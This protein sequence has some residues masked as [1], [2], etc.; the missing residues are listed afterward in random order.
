LAD[1]GEHLGEAVIELLA[2]QR[3]I[4]RLEQLP[5]IRDNLHYRYTC[6]RRGRIED[7]PV[8]EKEARLRNGDRMACLAIAETM[9]AAALRNLQQTR[10]RSLLVTEADLRIHRHKGGPPLEICLMVDASGSM[11]GHRIA[12]VKEL[13][14]RLLRQEREPLALFTF[15]EGDIGVKVSATRDTGKMRQ[16]ISGL[17]AGGMTPLGEAL[18]GAVKYLQTRRGK[19]HLL[20]LLTDGLPTWASGDTDPN[21]DALAAGVLVRR[22]GIRMICIGLE[23]QLDFLKKLAAVTEASLYIVSDLNHRELACI[24][25]RETGRLRR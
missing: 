7:G 24:T 3:E 25:R 23:P 21:E 9:T 18:R 14:G 8:R 2:V 5:A 19:K 10:G 1:G 22:A 11:M 17:R 4:R 6:V 13:V 12:E 15:Q 16:G 20:I